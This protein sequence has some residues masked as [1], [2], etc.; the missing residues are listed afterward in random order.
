MLSNTAD[1][2]PS[3]NA[4]WGDASGRPATGIIE[5]ATTSA[6]RNTA[7]RTALGI[8]DQSG[9]RHGVSS[10]IMPITVAPMNGNASPL[11][12]GSEFA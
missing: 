10:R 11:L 3:P 7:L 1:T 12:A 6:S 4:V 2:T 9:R 5:A 8:T